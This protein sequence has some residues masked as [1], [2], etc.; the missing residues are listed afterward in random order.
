MLFFLVPATVG[1]RFLLATGNTSCNE[2]FA[3]VAAMESA[4]H[5]D[6]LFKTI[7]KDSFQGISLFN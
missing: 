6:T 4:E 1:Q 2:V 7:F 3:K 5:D